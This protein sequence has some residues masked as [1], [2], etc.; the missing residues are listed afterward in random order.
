LIDFLLFGH[1]LS[2]AIGR[3]SESTTKHDRE[4]I[5]Q[6]LPASMSGEGNDLKT[7][8]LS[9]EEDRAKY[10]I[11]GCFAKGIVQINRT[12]CLFILGWIC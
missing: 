11:T 7:Q 10:M 1:D 4:I 2:V 5:L 8:L 6:K 12:M 3:I 9:N